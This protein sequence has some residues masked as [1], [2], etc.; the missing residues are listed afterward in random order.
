MIERISIIIPVLNE[1][2]NVQ[3]AISSALLSSETEVIV[4]DGGS[5]DHTITLSQT[6]GVQVLVSKAGRANQMNLGAQSASGDILLFLHADTR[7]PVGFDELIRQ[8]VSEHNHIA[9]AFALGIDAAPLRF[10]W[11]ERGVNWRSV[12]A[13]MPYGDQAIF[14][15][16]GVFEAIGGFPILPIMEDF[17]LIR[18]LQK[19]G[20]ITIINNPVQTSARRWLQRGILQ[21]T[22]INQLMVAGYLLGVDPVRLE[23]L[24]R[25]R[26][27]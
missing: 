19:L 6:L 20:K 14:L 16:A 8:A 17:A 21:T 26:K 15:R 13:Q 22:L 7:L 23:Q 1:A 11:L 27:F 4:V 25:R 12:Y 2:A 3:Q 18:Q 9:G 24:Y 5:T 10:R